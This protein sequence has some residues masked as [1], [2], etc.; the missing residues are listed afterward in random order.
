MVGFGLY[1]EYRRAV[2]CA[3]VKKDGGMRDNLLVQGSCDVSKFGLAPLLFKECSVPTFFYSERDVGPVPHIILEALPELCSG[4]FSHE[5]LQFLDKNQR[6][7]N[8]GY[9]A[10]VFI[11]DKCYGLVT[12]VNAEIKKRQPNKIDLTF[13]FPLA[14]SPK[15]SFL[16]RCTKKTLKTLRDLINIDN[17]AIYEQGVKTL[18][19]DQVFADSQIRL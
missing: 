15:T 4:R 7:A 10:T 8:L 13:V 3:L 12:A 2:D 17:I 11:R 9:D 18:E 1:R 16:T 5:V 6:H 14:D 19:G